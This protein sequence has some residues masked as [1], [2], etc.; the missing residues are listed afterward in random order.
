[1]LE[2]QKYIPSPQEF[3]EKIPLAPALKEVKEKRDEEIR[4]AL[5]GRSEKLLLIVGP[6]SAHA[7]APVIQYITRLAKLQECLA[8]KLVIVP[9]IYTSK[10]RTRGVGYQGMFLQPDFDGEADIVRGIESVRKLHI[11]VMEETG[12]TGAEEMLYPENVA[13][14]E[15]LVSY[16]A[17]GA[18]SVENPFHRQVASGL[19][20]PV[21]MKNP[22]SGNLNSLMDS[23]FAS[24]NA[25]AFKYRE[26]QVRSAGNPYAHAILRGGVDGNGADVPN[27]HYETVMQL[28]EMYRGSKLENPAIITLS[29]C[30]E[31]PTH[32]PI[33]PDFTR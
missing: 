22:T 27:F 17:V 4:A 12:L 15:D 19:D 3:L 10:P 29:S 14:L 28:E 23:V 25:Q 13:Y 24:Q 9:R 1:M 7:H 30:D 21:G 31:I 6:C 20:V 5:S 11:A 32:C 33:L 26:Y 8:D 2:K 16:F 18:R